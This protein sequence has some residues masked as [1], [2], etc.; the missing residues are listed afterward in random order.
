MDRR[1]GEKEASARHHAQHAVSANDARARRSYRHRSRRVDSR[2]DSDELFG[3]TE[4]GEMVVF[5]GKL[6]RSLIGHSFR[7]LSRAFEAERPRK[8]CR[9]RARH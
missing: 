7:R 9:G 6:D 4:L 3:H 8:A 5:N 1:R 2:N